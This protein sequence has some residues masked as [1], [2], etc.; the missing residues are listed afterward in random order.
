MKSTKDLEYQIFTCI[1]LNN[2]V[3][4][5][6]VF[7]EKYFRFKNVLNY[8]KEVYVKYGA[9]D[10]NILNTD[11]RMKNAAEVVVEL[12]QNE[13]SWRNVS[14]YYKQLKETYRENEIERLNNELKSRVINYEQY[15]QSFYELTLDDYDEEELLK[16]CDISN[17]I[18]VEREYTY[19]DELDYL[20]KGLEYGKLN[21]FSGITNHGK[22]TLMIQLAKNFIKRH[23]K[24]FY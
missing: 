12:L 2:K 8:F 14:G 16:P 20:L 21:L 4:D 15:K 24:V 3:L 1:L 22:T 6:Y 13:V 19:I 17:T 5:N 7:D 10:I 9:V 11:G 18:T 23:K